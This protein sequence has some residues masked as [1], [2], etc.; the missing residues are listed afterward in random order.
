MK[1]VFCRSLSRASTSKIIFK[2]YNA[3]FSPLLKT[4][5]GWFSSISHL[6]S[7]SI[8]SKLMVGPFLLRITSS[9][10]LTLSLKGTENL[11][12]NISITFLQSVSSNFAWATI[13]S[14]SSLPLLYSVS[15]SKNKCLYSFR[16]ET[17]T[18]CLKP[19]IFGNSG[20]IYWFSSK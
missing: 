18:F 19:L 16:Y 8:N 1:I 5:Y 6:S 14:I 7:L 11:W 4:L 20:S 17:Q 13:F 10:F 15:K 3:L 12:L 9:W 2:I